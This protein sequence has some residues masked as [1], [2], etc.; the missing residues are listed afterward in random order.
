MS[1][2]SPKA[3]KMKKEDVLWEKVKK[4]FPEDPALQ[5]VHYA[6]LKIH[7]ET[8]G[9]TS[10]EFVEYIFLS[11]RLS[12]IFTEFICVYLCPSVANS[13]LFFVDV[14]KSAY[15]RKICVI[16]VLLL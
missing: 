10:E 2:F 6:R 7:E 15:I 9:M 3:N 8:R 1:V 13:F 4:D 11:H 5:E 16:R 12:Q 14:L